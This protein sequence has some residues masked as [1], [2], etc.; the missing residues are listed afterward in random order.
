M[1]LSKMQEAVLNEAKTEID[2]YRQYGSL[3][4]YLK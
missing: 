3:D 2:K 1:K 4:K